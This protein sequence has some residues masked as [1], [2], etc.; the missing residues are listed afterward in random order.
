SS[1]GPRMRPRPPAEAGGSEGLT[2]AWGSVIMCDQTCRRKG[3]QIFA[4]SPWGKSWRVLT[5]VRADGQD[6]DGAITR[7]AHTSRAVMPAARDAAKPLSRGACTSRP[8]L[9]DAAPA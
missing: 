6:G 1:T 5:S 4:H 3:L 7:P 8:G 2:S 9:G